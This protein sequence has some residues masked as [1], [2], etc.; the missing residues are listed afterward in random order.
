LQHDRDRD[1][2]YPGIGRRGYEF[3]DGEHDLQMVKCGGPIPV[4]G[5]G[6]RLDG[7][8]RIVDI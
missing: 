8:N 6:K 4:R 7:I 5:V 1:N 3:V 2:G